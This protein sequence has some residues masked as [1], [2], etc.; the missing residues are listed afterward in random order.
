MNISAAS[1]SAH[2]IYGPKGV[3]FA[4]VKGGFNKL[5][6]L[7]FGGDQEFG[8]RAGTLANH[9]IA[10]LFKA[11]SIS[12]KS[13]FK[14]TQEL[15]S[16]LIS[17]LKKIPN[18]IL[19][20]DNSKSIKTIINFR[21]KGVD[22]EILALSMSNKVGLSLGSSCNSFKSERSH[23]LKSIGLTPKEINE[24]LRVSLGKY[25]TKADL[26]EFIK[27]LKS[28]ITRIKNNLN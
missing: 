16:F 4:Y 14:K 2:K 25:N 9:Q 19:N 20:I 15:G 7:M 23:V 24:S 8:K 18:V 1:I 6:P 26:I 17:E 10:G 28:S 5:T 13:D 11:T 22:A 21:V 12:K 27:I 3:G